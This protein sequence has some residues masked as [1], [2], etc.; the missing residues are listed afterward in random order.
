MSYFNKIDGFQ[1]G[2]LLKNTPAQLFSY[3]F[4]EMFTNTYS[5][6]HLRTAAS[7]IRNAKKESRTSA[8]LDKIGNC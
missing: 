3:E 5:V 4:Y 8:P 1:A 2:T 6:E 7:D